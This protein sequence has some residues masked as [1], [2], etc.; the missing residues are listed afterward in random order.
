MT[1]EKAEIKEKNETANYEINI[2]YPVFSGPGSKQLNERI[3]SGINTQITGLKNLENDLQPISPGVLTGEFKVWYNNYQM[4]SMEMMFEKAVPGTSII[5][6][7]YQ[8]QNFYRSPGNKTFFESTSSATKDAQSYTELRETVKKAWR[9]SHEDL[10]CEF[11]DETSIDHFAFDA[12]NVYFFIDLYSGN[13]ICQWQLV[14]IPHHNIAAL[15]KPELESFL[16][17]GLK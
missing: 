14:S 16:S 2:E 4:L 5:L 12:D 11:D 7:E 9:A 3:S 17:L 13:P 15:M 1:Y 8:N 10:P 6:R